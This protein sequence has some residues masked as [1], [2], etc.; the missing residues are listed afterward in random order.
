MRAQGCGNVAR[1]AGD[2]GGDCAN[3]DHEWAGMRECYIGSTMGWQQGAG[4][5]GP[6]L[7]T[8]LGNGI[9]LW[10]RTRDSKR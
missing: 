2:E 10:G 3:Q 5:K 9:I 4:A 6:S 7:R 1:G 8:R